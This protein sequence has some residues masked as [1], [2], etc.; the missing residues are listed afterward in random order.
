MADAN[1]PE[2]GVAFLAENKNKPGVVNVQ[3]VL[4]SRIN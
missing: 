4:S 3:S 1:G 2:A